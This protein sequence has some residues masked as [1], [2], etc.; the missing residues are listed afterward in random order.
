MIHAAFKSF[1]KATELLDEFNQEKYDK[2][3]SR[4]ETVDGFEDSLGSYLVRLNTLALSE[5][6]TRTV[7]KYL[8]CITNVER[9]SDHA[10]NLA[11]LAKEL[12]DKGIRFSEQAVNDLNMLAKATCEI[13]T[14]TAT[15]AREN[16]IETAKTVE[17]LEEVID[18]LTRKVRAQHI[19]RLQAGNCTLELGFVFNECLGNFERA[20]D[21]CSNIAVSVLEIADSNLQA[22]SYL[23]TVKNSADKN[24]QSLFAEYAGKFDIELEKI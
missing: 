10:V 21:H 7:A 3:M 23:H 24:Y 6:E 5:K 19:K 17:P 1:K 12:A 16:D 18:I 2:I 9:I 13:L 20:A 22:H 11:E 15:A 4:E 8:S 14:L